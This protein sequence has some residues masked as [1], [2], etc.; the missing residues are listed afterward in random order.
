MREV[1]TALLTVGVQSL[2]V[3]VR[4]DLV[5]EVA[6]ARQWVPLPGARGEVPGV[7]V[8]A[9][10]AVAVIDLAR[11]QPGLAPLAEGEAR[12]RLVIVAC[13]GS[14]L[15]LPADR[16]SEV[17]KVH[18]D[19]VAP[20]HV[21]DFPLAGAEIVFEDRVLPLFDPDLLLARLGVGA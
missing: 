14:T 5:R 13:G 4:A 8:W 12:P 6:G 18:D 10:R 3:A 15:A 2:D 16:V 21:S 20:R 1:G 19:K 9:G 11:F 17:W 7:V